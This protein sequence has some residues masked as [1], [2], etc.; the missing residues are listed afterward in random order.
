VGRK[1]V[2]IGKVAPVCRS[3]VVRELRDLPVLTI[4]WTVPEIAPIF[5]LGT[6]LSAKETR[7]MKLA[8]FTLLAALV[9]AGLSGCAEDQACRQAAMGQQ[10]GGDGR[11]CCRGPMPD[12]PGPPT[13]EVTYPYYTLHGPRDFLDANPRSIG[14]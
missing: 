4:F 9:L 5:P 8:S 3:A 11:G 14:P 12:T 10:G 1:V 7:P 2:F 6:I 13:A